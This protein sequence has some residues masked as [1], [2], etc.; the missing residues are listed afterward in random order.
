MQGGAY[1]FMGSGS[2]WNEQS[3]LTA[4]DGYSSDE[5]AFLIHCQVIMPQLVL[6]RMILMGISTKDL[7]M[8]SFDL[9]PIGMSN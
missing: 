7:L 1:I 4:S 2:V 9:D 3:I 5:L 6:T 8:S